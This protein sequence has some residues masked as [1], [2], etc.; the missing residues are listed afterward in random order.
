MDPND[1]H[2]EET[3]VVPRD[4]RFFINVPNEV[5]TMDTQQALSVDSFGLISSIGFECGGNQA[6]TANIYRNLTRH[7]FCLDGR[8]NISY[9]NSMNRDCMLTLDASRWKQPKD[10]V[11]LDDSQ[12]EGMFLLM[13]SA[14]LVFV[15]SYKNNLKQSLTVVTD[16][17]DMCECESFRSVEFEP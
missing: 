1:K 8:F 17:S 14:T 5:N 2:Y 4:Q 3:F 15:K 6:T 13:E 10:L 11:Q 9:Q 12:Y 16:Y 7:I